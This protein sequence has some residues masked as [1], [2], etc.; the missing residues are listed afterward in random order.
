MALFSESVVSIIK[1]LSKVLSLGSLMYSY[2]RFDTL[3]SALDD[4]LLTDT[5]KGSRD[6]ADKVGSSL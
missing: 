5:D 2:Y 1:S 3:N 6:I 4:K